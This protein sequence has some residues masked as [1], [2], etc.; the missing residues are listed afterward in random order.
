VN[1]S[2]EQF[3]T[4]FHIYIQI[5]FLLAPF[6]AVSIFLMMSEGMDSVQRRKAATRTSAAILILICVFFF[7]G[8]PLFSIL[9]ITLHAFQIGTGSVL[10]LTSIMRVMGIG[11]S[12]H[13]RVDPDDDF[14]I[15]PLAI[16]II[17]GPGTIGA[18]LVYGTAVQGVAEIMT[19]FSAVLAGG[20]TVAVFVLLAE[21]IEQWLGHKMLSMIVK[22]TALMLTALAAQI[23]FTGI[24]GFMA[25]S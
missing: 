5:L 15:V 7:F 25:G 20:I 2:F 10:F 16:P 4:F 9:G 8:K 21:R 23:I 17:V 14:S 1:L 19:T 24:K 6:F 22:V 11:S 3:R 13:R 12:N 18:L